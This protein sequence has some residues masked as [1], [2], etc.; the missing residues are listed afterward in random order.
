MV[1]LYLKAD[2]G[3][4]EVSDIRTREVF[5]VGND[6]AGLLAALKAIDFEGVMASSSVDFATEYGF[7]TQGELDELMKVFDVV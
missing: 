3:N 7:A 5:W 4:L 2:E 6:Y 1:D